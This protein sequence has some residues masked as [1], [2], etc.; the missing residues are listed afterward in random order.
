MISSILNIQ[1]R[2]CGVNVRIGY[3]YHDIGVGSK[4]INESRKS[5]IAD[6]HP[7]KLRLRL[8]AGQFELFHNV[9]NLADEKMG[10]TNE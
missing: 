2:S 5:R 9:G 10:S 7:L 8:A 1:K 4:G 6:F 3:D